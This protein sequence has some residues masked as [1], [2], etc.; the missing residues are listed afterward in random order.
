MLDIAFVI[1]AFM[2][3][4]SFKLFDQRQDLLHVLNPPPRANKA[5][6]TV[7]AHLVQTLY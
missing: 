3:N 5:L 4:I 7:F 6:G 1:P 2:F